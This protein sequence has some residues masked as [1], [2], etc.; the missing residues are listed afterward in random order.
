MAKFRF[1]VFIC[2][3]G[4][5]VEAKDQREQASWPKRKSRSWRAAQKTSTWMSW[6]KAKTAGSI[7][8]SGKGPYPGPSRF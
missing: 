8:A 6:R 3:G 2:A 1:E 5:E 4:V 7:T